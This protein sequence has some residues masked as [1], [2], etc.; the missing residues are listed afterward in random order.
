MKIT[1][2]SNVWQIICLPNDFILTES[3]SSLEG[4]KK[5]RQAILDKRIEAFLSETI[6]TIEAINKDERQNYLGSRKP[7]V[8][9]K[10]HP[11]TG[12]THSFTLTIGPEK[13][14]DFNGR[15]VLKKYFD[16]AIKLGFKIASLPRISGMKNEEIET[17]IYKQNEDELLKYLDKVVEIVQKIENKGAG[18]AQIEKIGKQ[19]DTINWHKGLNKSPEA[20]NTKIAKA[21]AEWADGDS[22]AISIALGCD[23][24][25]TRDQAKG[26]GSKSVL[27]ANNLAWLNS[28]Y[29][30]K[31]ILPE[32]LAKLI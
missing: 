2:D 9:T 25:C 17:V 5:I 21:A 4:F 22:V 6:F 29:G 7:K 24:F 16:E 8:E 11:I 3:E 23:Y 12:N 14:I 31:T 15:A 1:F 10:E 20:E 18:M 30:F 27:S 13:G 19:Y 28:D 32:N 26:A